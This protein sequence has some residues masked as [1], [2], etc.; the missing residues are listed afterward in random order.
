MLSES[1]LM[2]FRTECIG[3][4]WSSLKTPTHT[5]ARTHTH[6]Y[7]LFIKFQVTTNNT[8]VSFKEIKENTN[9][10]RQSCQAN[11]VAVVCHYKNT[12]Q[13]KTLA[14]TFKSSPHLT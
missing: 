8:V 10:F 1:L 4:R 7:R 5:H 6:V 3:M 12:Q 2:H 14:D 9:N 11:T 13:I